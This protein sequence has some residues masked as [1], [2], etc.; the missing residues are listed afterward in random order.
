[1]T[2]AVVWLYFEKGLQITTENVEEIAVDI[3]T[4]GSRLYLLG[5]ENSKTHPTEPER[6]PG[7]FLELNC[8][9]IDRTTDNQNI[10]WINDELQMRFETSE[11]FI[12][13]GGR[14]VFR[15]YVTGNR[16]FFNVLKNFLL[17]RTNAMILQGVHYL[18]IVRVPDGFL[19]VNS[20][21]TFKFDLFKTLDEVVLAVDTFK[22]G[23]VFTIHCAYVIRKALKTYTA[24]KLKEDLE[25]QADDIMGK[26]QKNQSFYNGIIERTK[27]G[28]IDWNKMVPKEETFKILKSGLKKFV[29][30]RGELFSI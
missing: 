8:I 3:R 22:D 2:I 26:K 16:D 17:S 29:D 23:E 1:M 25:K 20:L 10:I 6:F 24:D 21:P 27:N 19:L 5:I 9:F 11:S 12:E 7:Q 4:I 15:D 28:N 30:T 18:T 14:L 13:V